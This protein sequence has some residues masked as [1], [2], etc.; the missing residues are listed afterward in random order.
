MSIVASV[1]P[2]SDRRSVAGVADSVWKFVFL[3]PRLPPEM[4]M[5]GM[6]NRFIRKLG[7]VSRLGR[8]R[9]SSWVKVC[10]MDEMFLF[11]SSE[12]MVVPPISHGVEAST[13]HTVRL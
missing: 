6:N 3:R 9:E 5:L 10:R 8:T 11:D 1:L 13:M 12:L 4:G 2:V 7:E